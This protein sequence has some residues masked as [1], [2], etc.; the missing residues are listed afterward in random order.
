M[1]VGMMED[2]ERFVSPEGDRMAIVDMQSGEVWMMKRLK[3][4][5]AAGTIAML[6]RWSRVTRSPSD[7]RQRRHPPA[8]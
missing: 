6:P 2:V 1:G 5:D 8:R 4:A 3:P 7:H